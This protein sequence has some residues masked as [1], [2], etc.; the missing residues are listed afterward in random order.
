MN[1]EPPLDRLCIGFVTKTT[2]S[3]IR[4]PGNV[5]DLDAE[6]HKV[7]VTGQVQQPVDLTGRPQ[8]QVAERGYRI[9]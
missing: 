3:Y 6:T 5:P 8:S 4:S 2:D 1:A 9:A 7:R